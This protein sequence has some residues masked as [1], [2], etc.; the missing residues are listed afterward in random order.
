MLIVLATLFSAFT[1]YLLI[2]YIA[3]LPLILICF[4]T[5]ASSVL[6]YKLL[7]VMFEEDLYSIK[8][9]CYI[10]LTCYTIFKLGFIAYHLPLIYPEITSEKGYYKSPYSDKIL[11]LSQEKKR[12][13]AKEASSNTAEYFKNFKQMREH[14]ELKISTGRLDLLIAI[15]EG[16]SFAELDADVIMLLYQE[17][18]DGMSYESFISHLENFYVTEAQTNAKVNKLKQDYINK[19]YIDM[20]YTPY[21]F[22]ANEQMDENL[23]VWDFIYMFIAVTFISAVI[24]LIIFMMAMVASV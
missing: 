19:A 17:F 6:F 22:Y 24:L 10:V 21:K 5:I 8:I 14:L 16:Q 13:I 15:K 4:G 1:G 18:G 3:I 7:L 11:Y 2:D 23:G 9:F 12:E 20:N